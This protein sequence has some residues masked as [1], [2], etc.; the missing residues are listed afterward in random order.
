MLA[1]ER[2]GKFRRI[3]I[4]Q[5]EEKRDNKKIEESLND[6]GDNRKSNLDLLGATWGKRIEQDK[7]IWKI[8]NVIFFRLGIDRAVCIYLFYSTLY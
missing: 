1:E 2:I 7:N 3:E 4:I 6:L 5:S 8:L